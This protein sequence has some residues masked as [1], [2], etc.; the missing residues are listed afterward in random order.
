M[1]SKCVCVCVCMRVPAKLLQ[2][3]LP[4]CDPMDYRPPVS[5]VYGIL[6][7][8]NTGVDCYALLQGIFPT[9][10][11]NPRLLKYIYF[12]FFSIISYYKI[13]NMIPCAI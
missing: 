13:L 12:R 4:L 1:Y 6:Q 10:G 8:K 5:S 3:C 9:Q 11:L 2:S 7:A